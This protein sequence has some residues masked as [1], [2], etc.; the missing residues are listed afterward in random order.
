MNTEARE[1]ESTELD[2]VSGGMKWTP[3]TKNDDVID[4]RGGQIQI[5]GF[6]IT[7]DVK[8]NISSVSH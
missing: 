5:L 3:G 6:N 7:F 8:G 4:A 2:A 1:L